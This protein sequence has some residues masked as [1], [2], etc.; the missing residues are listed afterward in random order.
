MNPRER[1]Q[2]RLQLQDDQIG[3]ALRESEARGELRAAPSWGRPMAEAEG[4]EQ[5]PAE[6]RLPFK[7]LKD[8]GVLPPEVETMREITALQHDLDA[9]ADPA[10]QRVLQQRIAEKRQHLALRLEKLRRSGSL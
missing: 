8:A 3:Q 7:I 2:Q 1:R 10:A 5:T 6:F 9:T 4:W